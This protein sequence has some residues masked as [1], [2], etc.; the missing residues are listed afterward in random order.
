VGWNEDGESAVPEY[1]VDTEP[2][3][4]CPLCE[5][6]RVVETPTTF[7][8]ESRLKEEEEATA[9]DTE[10][11]G[12]GRKKKAEKAC[13]FVLPRTVCKREIT[14]DEAVHYL[15]HRRTELLTDFTSRYGRPFAATLV[16]KDNGRH[17]FE[18]QP[19]GE[20]RGGAGKKAGGKKTTRKAA[21]G[22]T[23]R[24]KAASGRKKT[25]SRGTRRAAARSTGKK[26]SSKKA[27]KKKTTRKGSQ[28]KASKKKSSR[29]KPGP[30][31]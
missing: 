14:R 23:T 22:K 6:H 28:K 27:S 29:K 31:A 5:E 16:L 7:E 10:T 20:G 3:G 25:G 1:D 30:D 12:R 15:Q 9:D 4:A 26:A 13:S 2:L 21:S 18:F 8:C 17:G 11:A 19:R 24:K